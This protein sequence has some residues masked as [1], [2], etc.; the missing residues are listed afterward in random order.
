MGDN[1]AHV[2]VPIVFTIGAAG[3]EAQTARFLL[4]QIVV[5]T[6]EGW[7]VAS[8]LPIPVPPP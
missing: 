4:N 1:M 5:K 3:Q 2:Y 6:S 7:R 8:I